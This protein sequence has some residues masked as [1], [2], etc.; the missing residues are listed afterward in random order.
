[1]KYSGVATASHRFAYV[2][3]CLALLQQAQKLSFRSKKPS[4]AKQGITHGI[5]R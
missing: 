2:A 5:T 1:M 3:I 4:F